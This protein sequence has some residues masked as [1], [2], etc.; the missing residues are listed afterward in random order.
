M[1]EIKKYTTA[2]GGSVAGLEKSVDLLINNGWQP[3][4][5]AYVTALHICQPMVAYSEEAKTLEG[6]QRCNQ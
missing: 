5:G 1:Q 6:Y 2:M 3:F 4:G